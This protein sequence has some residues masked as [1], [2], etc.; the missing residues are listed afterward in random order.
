MIARQYR[1]VPPNPSPPH[2]HT[3]SQKSMLRK[4]SICVHLENLTPPKF[5]LHAF[6]F[7]AEIVLVQISVLNLL[8]H[9]ALAF[10]CFLCVLEL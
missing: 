5:I 1:E 8:G 10:S 7:A 9:F 2:L 4:A 3:H 6:E